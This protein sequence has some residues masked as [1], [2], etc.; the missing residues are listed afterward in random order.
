MAKC[1][2]SST[3]VVPFIN[4]IAMQHGCLAVSMEDAS[5]MSQRSESATAVRE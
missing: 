1:D 2:D 3:Y 5:C 4:I